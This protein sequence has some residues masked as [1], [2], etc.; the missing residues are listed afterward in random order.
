NFQQP[1]PAATYKIVMV[2]PGD[3]VNAIAEHLADNG[4]IANSYLFRVGLRIRGLQTQLKA[5][6]YGFPAHASMADIAGILISGKS[7]QHKLTAAEGLTSAMIYE[8]VKA[9]RV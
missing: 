8:T 5:G 1:G 7:I 3:H 2:E 6:E 9:D 4:V